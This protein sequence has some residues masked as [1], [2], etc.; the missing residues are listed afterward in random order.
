MDLEECT[1]LYW[2]VSKEWQGEGNGKL[3]VG[4]ALHTLGDVYESH[5]GRI[6]KVHRMAGDLQIAVIRNDK[7]QGVK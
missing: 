1:Q 7:T 3:Q 2:K 4:D 6:M 5:N